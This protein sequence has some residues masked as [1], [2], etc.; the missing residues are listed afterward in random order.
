MK[1]ALLLCTY[2][3]VI[4]LT[5]SAPQV[6]IYDQPLELCSKSPKTGY[7]RNGYC[8]TGP[9]DEGTHVLCAE[10][11]EE[12]LTFTKSK[13]NDLSTPAPQYSFPGLVAGD[14]WCLCI[15]RWLQAEAA[16]KA[17]PIKLEAT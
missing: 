4:K 13:G 14:K 12:F 3:L 11:T 1:S 17:P 6:N 7:Y 2:I 5:L 10:V 8:N 9:E 15:L 16:G